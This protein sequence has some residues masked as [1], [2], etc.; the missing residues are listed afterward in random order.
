[1]SSNFFPFQGKKYES[2]QC[3]CGIDTCV[4][5]R[6]KFQS[7][8]D[9]R[10]HMQKLPNSRNKSRN[11][12]LQIFNTRYLNRCGV[13][14]NAN[15]QGMDKQINHVAENRREKTQKTDVW[16]AIWHFDKIVL[17]AQKAPFQTVRK[18]MDLNAAKE[19]NGLFGTGKIYSQADVIESKGQDVV[20][21]VPTVFNVQKIKSEFEEAKIDKKVFD[22]KKNIS[23]NTTAS[24]RKRTTTSRVDEN[25]VTITRT[26]A[27][28]LP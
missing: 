2:R 26:D 20:A 19:C 1:M 16:I 21:I 7:I 24:K 17:N 18:S 11:G 3:I 27:S 6:Q 12:N 10:G 15:L 9:I 23:S 14:R 28:F 8:G 4:S 22:A 13:H 25:M 5:I